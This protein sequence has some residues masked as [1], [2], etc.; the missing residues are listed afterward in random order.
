MA[1]GA[2]VELIIRLGNFQLFKELAGHV[3]IVVLAGM[4]E[5]FAQVGL[6]S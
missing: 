1:A 2:N 6:I 5:D 4:D 3:V